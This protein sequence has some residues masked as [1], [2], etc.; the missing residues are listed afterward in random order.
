MII[1]RTPFRISLFGGGSDYPAWY[2]RHGGAVLGFAIRKYCYVSVRYLPPFFAHKHRIIYSKVENVI[3]IEEI[4]HPAV[5]AILRHAGIDKGLEIHHDADLPARSGMGSSSSF[6]VGLLNALH[7][8][9]GRMMDKRTLAAEALHMEQTVMAENVGTQ[10]QLWATYG[11]LNRMI[12]RTDGTYDVSPLIIPRERREELL[13]HCMLF[14]TGLQR[15]ATTVAEKQIAN[16]DRRQSQIRT[17]MQMVDEASDILC[18]PSRSMGDIGGLLHDAWRLKKELSD[19]V[20]TPL[21]D[22]IHQASMDAGALGGKL[23]GA[24]GGGFMLLFAP[25][26][27]HAAIRDALRHLVEVTIDVDHD[28]S[29]IVVYEPDGLSNTGR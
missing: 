28:G 26:E 18:T 27:R 23:L 14:F 29:R 25:P 21:V 2:C 22:E 4:Q 20:S 10:D 8:L 5:R 24:G 3:E 12:F 15:Y 6:V 1:S 7:A 16:L 19:A 17:M 9:Q 13:S 11:G